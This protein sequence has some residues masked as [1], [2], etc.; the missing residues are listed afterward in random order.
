[1]IN[2]LFNKTN[3]L[4]LFQ[5]LVIFIIGV[6]IESVANNRILFLDGVLTENICKS[7]LE[8]WFIVLFILGSINIVIYIVSH[9]RLNSKETQQIYDNICELIFSNYIKHNSDLQNP[10]FRVSLFQA[11]KG[12]IFRRKK[13]FIPE[14]RTILINV[15]RY[16]TR[17]EKKL[18]KI[19]FL[20]DEGAVGSCFSL[21]EFMFKEV[22]KYDEERKDDYY[23]N[24]EN[25]LYL[26][27]FKARRLNIKSS[28]FICCPV[29][30]FN[31][32]ELFGVIVVDCLYPNQMS[33]DRFRTIEETIQ[34]YTVFFTK[35]N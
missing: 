17:Q 32:D 23:K 19:K 4:G 18:C 5:A 1:M 20:P 7:L 31:T 15:G 21:G 13:R 16:Q 22:P 28:S 26:P 34:H 33:K 29:K 12:L 2:Q 10:D 8:S 24:Q 25:E 27:A 30:Y 6:Y 35:K 11:R 9:N 3:L 14:Y